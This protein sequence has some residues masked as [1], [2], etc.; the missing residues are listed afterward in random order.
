M[1]NLIQE[2]L[3]PIGTKENGEIIGLLNEERAGVLHLYGRTGQGKSVTLEGVV[4]S[5]IVNGRG[6][7][8]IEPYGDLVKDVQ[9]YIPVDKKNKVAVFEAKEKTLEENIARFEKEIDFNEMKKDNQKYLLCKLDYQTLGTDVAKELGVYL[10][11]QFLKVVGGENRS[12]VLD[13][14]HNFLSEEV[15]EQILQSKEKGLLSVLCDQTSL[16]Y[17][18]DI[19]KRLLESVNYVVS[20]RL[21]EKTASMINKYHSEIDK[22]ELAELEKYYLIAKLNSGVVKLKG[23]YPIPYLKN[24]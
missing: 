14:A 7:M 5:E 20:Y 24:E 12:L 6:G 16:H 18:E 1:G 19:H 9:L 22:S 15:L 2:G 3:M 4:V 17:R 11:N 21:D 13:E 8:F 23:I 10:V